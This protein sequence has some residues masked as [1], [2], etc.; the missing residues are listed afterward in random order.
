MLS[1]DL[2]IPPYRILPLYQIHPEIGFEI[3][4]TNHTQSLV[5]A[6]KSTGQFFHVHNPAGKEDHNTVD[7]KICLQ[8]YGALN[9]ASGGV[10]LPC[11][12]PCSKSVR[13]MCIARRL[14]ES[15][16]TLLAG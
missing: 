10:E 9:S 6:H 1:I 7:Y 15:I 12:L 13:A 8:A 5:M 2:E 14:R 16:A 11:R 3:S 4:P